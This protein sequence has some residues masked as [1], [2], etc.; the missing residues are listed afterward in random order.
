MVPVVA[1]ILAAMYGRNNYASLQ[2]SCGTLWYCGHMVEYAARLLRV[3]F[4]VCN[5]IAHV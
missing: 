4:L 2:L 5:A 1:L 3:T